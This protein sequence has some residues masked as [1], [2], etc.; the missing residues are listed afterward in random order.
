MV[1]PKRFM[2]RCVALLCVGAAVW[3]VLGYTVPW[4]AVLSRDERPVV[5][6][7]NGTWFIWVVA[8]Q[9]VA[10]AAATLE[11]HVESARDALN[12][13]AIVG[14]TSDASRVAERSTNATASK[15]PPAWLKCRA[16][17]AASRVFPT[18]PGPSSVRSRTSGD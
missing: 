18:P 13:R 12:M 5:A 15:P 10:V 3:I 17:A 11:P 2:L 8:S 6:E 14:R 16:A 4:V 9:S 1:A 7:A